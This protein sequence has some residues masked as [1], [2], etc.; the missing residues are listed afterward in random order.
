[1]VITTT[2][3]RRA[4]GLLTASL[5]TAAGVAG[6]GSAETTAACTKIEA[7]IAAIGS[8]TSVTDPKV[9]KETYDGTALKIRE[10]AEGTEVADETE[11]VASAMEKLGTQVSGFAANPSTK[12][13]QLDTAGLTSAGTVLQKACS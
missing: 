10:I 6:C 4:T 12:M 8:K 7:E 5:L 11:Q 2:G 3:A 9:L 1:M 13:P